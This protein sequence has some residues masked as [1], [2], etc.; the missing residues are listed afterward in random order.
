MASEA[1][2]FGPSSAFRNKDARGRNPHGHI[3]R[4]LAIPPY[5][6]AKTCTIRD[7]IQ[8][9]ALSRFMRFAFSIS[10]LLDISTKYIR[11]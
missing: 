10:A 11:D 6:W 7:S 4:Q 5:P 2:H 8:V 3:N 1:R 9:N